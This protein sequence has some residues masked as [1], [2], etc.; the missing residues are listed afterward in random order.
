MVLVNCLATNFDPLL[1]QWKQPSVQQPSVSAVRFGMRLHNNEIISD[2]I[3]R[4]GLTVPINL[5][6]CDGALMDNT[7][8][9]RF[10]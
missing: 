8:Y 7:A 2:Y 1:N 9:D 3:F 10:Q 5:M 4:H 6:E